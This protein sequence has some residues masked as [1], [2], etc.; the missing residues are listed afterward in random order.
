MRRGAPPPFR[1]ADF[2]AR[3]ADPSYA[4]CMETGPVR[5]VLGVNISAGVAYLVLVH[6]PEDVRFADPVQMAPSESVRDGARLREFGARFIQ[7]VKRLNV[8]K[9][10]VAHPRPRPQ[11]GWPYDEAF[12]RASLEATIMLM[13]HDAGIEYVSLS[14]FDAAAAV[15][16]AKPKDVTKELAR[17]RPDGRG[18]FWDERATALMVALALA[19]D[20]AP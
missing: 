2:A 3:L 13:L 16:V 7:E 12:A 6:P 5:P 11:R 17:F 10:G 8:A 14:Q 9:V 4:P 18:V 20:G 1:G 15:G 19:R